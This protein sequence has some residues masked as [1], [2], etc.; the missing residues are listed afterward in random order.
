MSDPNRKGIRFTDDELALFRAAM[1]RD[2]FV[3]ERG[4]TTWI[5]KV[6]WRYAT[7]QLVPAPIRNEVAD[8]QLAELLCGITPETL[9]SLRTAK[10]IGPNLAEG[11]EPDETADP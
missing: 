5:K 11:V 2:G 8:R 10:P 3:G 1:K 6:C 4:L 9:A 7:G